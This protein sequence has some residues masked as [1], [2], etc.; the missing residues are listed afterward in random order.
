MQSLPR[1]GYVGLGSYLPPTVL[2]NETL[3]RIVDTSD[4]WIV[5]R[6]GIRT[7]RILDKS[8]SILDMAERASRQALERAGVHPEEVSDI[9]VGVNTWL[10]FP[11]LA[12]QLQN[13]LGARA[14]SASDVSA[15][16]AGFIYAVEEAHNKILVDKLKYGRERISL[17]VGVEALSHIT[18]WT[19]R[20]TCVLF[21]DGA[22][23]V[24]MREVDEGGILAI[25]TH[26]QGEYGDLLHSTPLLGNQLDDSAGKKFTHEQAGP[27]AY[28][29]MEGPKVYTVAIRTM[30]DDIRR[31]VA[32]YNQAAQ[33]PIDLSDIDYVY[34]HQANLR[35][36]ERVAERLGVDLERVY[37]EGVVNYGNTS[38]ASIPIGYCDEHAHPPRGKKRRIEVDVAFGAGFASGA[39]LREVVETLE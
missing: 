25:H 38:T 26:A 4:E 6:T 10:R 33:H 19:D 21:G 9:R 29:E 17:V 39:I 28:L 16:C 36:I 24:V 20:R 7:R 27:R 13:R 22:G 1:I 2:D 3:S 31:V 5:Q 12:T 14:A 37:T 11:S 32:N 18:N 30:V 15:G 35:I 23:A 8:E 34:P